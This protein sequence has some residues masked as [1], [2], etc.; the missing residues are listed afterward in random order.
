MR[1]PW[2][3][4]VLLLL[5]GAG[6]L[7]GGLGLIS[8]SQRLGWILLAHG[9]VGYGVVAVLLW[10]GA[11]IAAS[12]RR[13]AA[14]RLARVAFLVLLVLLLTLLATGIAWAIGGPFFLGPYSFMTIH[15]TLG[16]TL[17]TV[18]SWHV[19]SMRF[20][21]RTPHAADRRMFLRLVG[22]T[23]AG[24]VVWQVSGGLTRA[25]KLPGS[26]RRFT[27]SYE[28]GSFTGAFPAVSWLF[29][30]PEPTDPAH[31]RLAV[32]GEV[33]KEVMLSYEQFGALP[34]VTLTATL[35]CTGGWYSAQEW[36]GV[37]LAYLLEAAHIRSGAGSVTVEAVSGYSRRFSVSEARTYLLATHVAGRP[38]DHEHGFPVR[39]VAPGHRGLDWVK[40]VTHI[41]VNDTNKFWQLPVPLQ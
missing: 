13:R 31:W 24:A 34:Q 37:S 2:V 27:G 28:T 7:S 10:K 12:L 29:D 4:V 16:I 23:L 18:F 25:F 14:N 30:Y 33:E 17:L 5:L 8:G 40:W 26:T 20:I 38:L 22:M 21:F 36:T 15:T 35:D 32:D 9:I 1:Y 11:I 6:L 3:N 39:L 19:F 41:R